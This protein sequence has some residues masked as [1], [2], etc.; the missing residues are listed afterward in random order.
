MRFRHRDTEDTQGNSPFRFYSVLFVTLWLSCLICVHLWLTPVFNGGFGTPDSMHFT[1]C[2][3]LETTCNSRPGQQLRP[4][5][6]VW[7]LALP[8]RR[9]VKTRFTACCIRLHDVGGE[10]H[11]YAV[12]KD[13]DAGGRGARAQHL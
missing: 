13:L 1:M 5:C 10:G 4:D 7:L 11:G 6:Q 2:V 9:E 8:A 3:P 12:V